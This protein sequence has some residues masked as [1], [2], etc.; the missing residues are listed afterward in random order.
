MDNNIVASPRF[1]EI[2]AEIRDL[3]FLPNAKLSAG[4]VPVQ[5]RV[6]FNQGVDARILCK[7]PAYLRQLATICLKPLRI[8][9]DHLGLKIP[10]ER[11]VRYAHE[12][13]L[14]NMSNYM[15]Y[16]FHDTPADLFERMRLNVKLNE[17]LGLRIWSFPMRYQ[18]TWLPDRS[19]IGEHWTR[20]QLRA[21]QLILQATHGVVSGEP[22]FFKRAF[23]DTVQDFE[24]L[25]MRPH[26]FI[27]NRDWYETYGGR[28]QFDEFTREFR[29]L[30][31]IERTEL[32]S[33]IASAD[34][35]EL[36]SK[37]TRACARPVR[38]IMKHYLPL[39][40]KEEAEIWARQKELKK[41]A[42]ISI[43][44]PDEERVEDA[45]L[46]YE[47]ANST[48]NRKEGRQKRVM[49]NA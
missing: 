16:N 3:G 14:M 19:H 25:L 1:R 49:A 30:S 12:F 27:F 35:S 7:D 38:S 6:D 10:Y 23:G 11:S 22:S 21:M 2:I 47:D 37:V 32:L 13:G 18:P 29:N 26:H 15:L 31:G 39:S 17:D 8:A 4:R 43:E 46:N 24:N 20:Y 9:F 34:P 28:A 48:S 41:H 42:T 45:G 44:V 36:R 33:L 40:K 5:R